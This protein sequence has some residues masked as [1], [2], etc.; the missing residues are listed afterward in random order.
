MRHSTDTS[1]GF[2]MGERNARLDCRVDW[3]YMKRYV[4]GVGQGGGSASSIYIWQDAGFQKMIK[5]SSA[6]DLAVVRTDRQPILKLPPDIMEGGM[7]APMGEGGLNV[8]GKTSVT[9]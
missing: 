8:Q 3:Q 5:D 9:D 4:E 6:C 1:W 2:T 7:P